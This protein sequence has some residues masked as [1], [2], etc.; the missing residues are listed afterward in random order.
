MKDKNL[1]ND[2]NSKSLEELTNEANSTIEL[3]ENEKDLQNSIENYQKLIRLNNIIEKKF[4]KKSK[5]INE[6][7]K[8]KVQAIIDKKNAR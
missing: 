2:N 5:E 1:P 7:T 4:Q 6:D 8:K 3:L